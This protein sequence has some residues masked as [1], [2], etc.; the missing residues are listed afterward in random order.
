MDTDRVVQQDRVVQNVSMPSDNI[1]MFPASLLFITIGNMT[2]AFSKTR[3]NGQ[4]SPDEF[5]SVDKR[6]RRCIL[7][8]RKSASVVR[9]VVWP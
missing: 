2:H 7:I 9:R 5:V 4:I 3:E 1:S 6:E 8:K